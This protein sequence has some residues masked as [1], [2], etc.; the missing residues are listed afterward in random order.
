VTDIATPSLTDRFSTWLDRWEAYRAGNQGTDPYMPGDDHAADLHELLRLLDA[1]RVVHVVRSE[2]PTSEVFAGPF[3]GHE[4]AHRWIEAN[5]TAA[6][7]HITVA[8]LERPAAPNDIPERERLVHEDPEL[9]ANIREGIAE[10]ERGGTADLGSFSPYLDD[11]GH[12]P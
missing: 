9:A 6:W 11:E 5:R 1:P 3:A 12:Q 7:K 10:A 4:D 2:G 8:P